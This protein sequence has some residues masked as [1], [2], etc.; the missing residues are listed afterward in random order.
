MALSHSTSHTPPSHAVVVPSPDT[1]GSSGGGGGGMVRTL[2]FALYETVISL[3]SWL[4]VTFIENPFGHLYR[5]GPRFGNY[6]FWQNRS[7]SEICSELTNVPA[8]HWNTFPYECDELIRKRIHS[9]VLILYT[10][11]YCIAFYNVVR[12]T[13]AIMRLRRLLRCCCGWCWSSRPRTSGASHSRS[14]LGLEQRPRSAPP[15]RRHQEVAHW[16]VE[17]KAE[18]CR[19]TGVADVQSWSPRLAA[20]AAPLPREEVP[21]LQPFRR[22]KQKSLVRV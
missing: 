12:N 8:D 5:S 22:A 1:T 20:T 6:G 19:E 18:S 4:A 13:L 3:F 11:L 14:A 21:V 9:W 15:T 2:Y 10:V 16:A 7:D 17:R